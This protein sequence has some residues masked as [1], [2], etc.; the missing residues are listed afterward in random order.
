MAEAGIPVDYWTR[1]LR[2]WH[3]DPGFIERLN[4]RLD[5]IEAMFKRGR[6]LCLVGHRGVGKTMAA[7]GILKRALEKDFT[8]HYTTMVEVVEQLVSR[9]AP[10]YRRRLRMVDF[11]AIDE[12][13]QRFFESPA[14][15]NLYGN[16]F[17]NVMRL[18]VQNR[19]PLVMCTNSEDLDQIFAGEFQQSFASLRSQFM[20]MERIRGR[21][22]RAREK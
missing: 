16:H 15:R 4:R 7:C 8:A 2:D 22:A 9:D 5:D 14:S 21:D 19:L 1:R 18:R 20:D 11:L 17:E 10:R 12:V 3:G 13:D 6:V